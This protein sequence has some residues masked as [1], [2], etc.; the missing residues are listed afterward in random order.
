MTFSVSVGS[1][2][3]DRLEYYSAHTYSLIVCL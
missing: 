1:E 2:W 3:S